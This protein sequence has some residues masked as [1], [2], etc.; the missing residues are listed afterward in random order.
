MLSLITVDG[1]KIIMLEIFVG[2]WTIQGISIST[3]VRINE[4]Y[5]GR[6]NVRAGFGS[7]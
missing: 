2:D 7:Q 5:A 3:L 1:S 6:K 4:L